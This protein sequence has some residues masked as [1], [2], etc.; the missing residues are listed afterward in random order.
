[1]RGGW[2]VV[3]AGP[4]GI[5]SV[6]KLLDNGVLPASI[7][8]VDPEFRVGD[9]G[10]RWRRVSSN[11]KAHLFRRF[12]SSCRSFGYDPG[13]MAYALDSIDPQE[14]CLIENVVEPLQGVTEKLASEVTAVRSKVTSLRREGEGFVAE[15]RSGLIEAEKVILAIGAEPLDLPFPL[16]RIGLDDALDEARLAAA[17][18]PDDTVAVFGSSHSAIMA[19]RNLIGAG[20]RKVVNFYRSPLRFAVDHGDWILYDNTGLKGRTAD[21]ARTMGEIPAERLLRVKSSAENILRYL[22][23]CTKV[24]YGIG[25]VPRRLPVAGVNLAGYDQR[26]G[27]VAPGLYGCGIAF[28]ERV[29]DRAG[30][31]EYNVGLWKFMHYLDRVVPVWMSAEGPAMAAAGP[32]G[33]AR[34]ATE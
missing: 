5:A 19:V 32:T 29:V 12:L 11:T 7:V 25:F 10:R 17:V 31:E 22:P 15:T 28:P 6:G 26:T 1:M 3:G 27:V 18:G 23:L 9:L 8:W 16:P 4:A 24:V 30:H 13:R 20:A 21:W 14:T 2:L 33:R 34:K